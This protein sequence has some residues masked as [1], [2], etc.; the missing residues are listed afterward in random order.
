MIVRTRI[1]ESL[2]A[3]IG[4]EDT[5]LAKRLPSRSEKRRASVKL[6]T[7]AV[8]RMRLTA[9]LAVAEPAKPV[10]FILSVDESAQLKK[11]RDHL[12]AQGQS[13]SRGELMRLAVKLLLATEPDA[14]TEPLSRLPRF[15]KKAK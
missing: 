15:P 2:R 8:N 10:E 11:L 14:L 4:D 6:T 13:V 1:K 9:S 3:S 5:A 12:R 7:K